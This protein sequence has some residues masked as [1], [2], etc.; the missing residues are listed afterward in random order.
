MRT[1][2]VVSVSIALPAASTANDRKVS[3]LTE[4]GE[5]KA[6][7]MKREASG[8]R[9]NEPEVTDSRREPPSDRQNGESV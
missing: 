7:T 8:V 1:S 4:R 6:M 5:Q 9:Q 2:A 3:A